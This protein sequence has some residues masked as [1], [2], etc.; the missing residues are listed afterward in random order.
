VLQ[1]RKPQ[2]EIYAHW[3]LFLLGYFHHGV[4]KLKLVR[5]QYFEFEFGAKGDR[6]VELFWCAQILVSIHV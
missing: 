2:V 5:T 3:L 4:V 1:G 6:E